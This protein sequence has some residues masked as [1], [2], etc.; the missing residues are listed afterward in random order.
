M[1]LAMSMFEVDL[2]CQARMAPCESKAENYGTDAYYKLIRVVRKEENFE[3]LHEM[4]ISQEGT[5]SCSN[6]A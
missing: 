2:L 3:D 6:Q 5:R 4:R 1:T